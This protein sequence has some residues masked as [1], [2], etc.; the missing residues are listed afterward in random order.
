[1]TLSPNARLAVYTDIDGSLAAPS[2]V[3]S[4]PGAGIRGSPRRRELNFLLETPSSSYCLRKRVKQED[5]PFFMGM[6]G[7][8][9][10]RLSAPL[11]SLQRMGNRCVDPR[12]ARSHR[13][14]P[15]G[16]TPRPD[17]DQCRNLSA[18]L[19]RFIAR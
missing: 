1:V 18:G 8:L 2:R 13:H 12:Q 5:L 4:R 11:P 16:M 10:E 7:H 9:A 14:L 3:R 19:A 6:M 17:I 15:A